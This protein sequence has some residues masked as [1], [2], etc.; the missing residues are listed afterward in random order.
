MPRRPLD[1]GLIRAALARAGVALVQ[2]GDR[3]DGL[4]EEERFRV[5]DKLNAALAELDRA[6]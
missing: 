6:L 2:A 1:R 4:D 5:I 3:V